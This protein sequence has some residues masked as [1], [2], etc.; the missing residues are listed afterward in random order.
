MVYF[1]CEFCGK[2]K[3]EPLAWF[4]KRKKHF[5]SRDCANKS[6]VN[7]NKLS[8]KEYEKA[9]W[10]KPENKARRKK[11]A[12]DSR[13]ARMAS[14]GESYI[15]AMLSRCKA[16]AVLKGLEFNLT[17]DDIYIPEYCPILNVKLELNEKQGGGNNSP[18]LDR[19]DNSKGYIKGNVQVISSKANRIKSDATIEEVG[20]VYKFLLQ[21]K[22]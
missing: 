4:K 14:L 12:N 10:D 1:N 6:R 20:L 17:I 7:P 11:M 13:I 19:I 18:A 5:C 16:R 3:E 22:E 9:Y 15:K 2:E 21:F 8:R